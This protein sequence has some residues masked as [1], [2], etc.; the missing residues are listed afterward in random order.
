MRLRQSSINK[1]SD[2][3]LLKLVENQKKQQAEQSDISLFINNRNLKPGNKLYSNRFLYYLYI[4]DGH[5]KISKT[6]FTQL[7]KVYLPYKR[8]KRI[9]GFA[10]RDFKEDTLDLYRSYLYEKEK[11]TQT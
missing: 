11:N 7:M 5:K 2:E 4:K 10:L 6:K 1:L 8:N 3:E 9:R